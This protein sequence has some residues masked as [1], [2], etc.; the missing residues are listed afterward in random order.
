MFRNERIEFPVKLTNPL[1]AILYISN[2]KTHIDELK[3]ALHVQEI[4]IG[5][6]FENLIFIQIISIFLLPK[7]PQQDA[8][9]IAIHKHG[10]SLGGLAT[11][12]WTLFFIL[13][14]IFHLFLFKL[15]YRELCASTNNDENSYNYKKNDY[16]R[17]RNTRTV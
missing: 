2:D 10:H 11:L 16:R 12:F 7:A 1:T 15:I 5:K 13:I 14:L 9:S 4:E 6:Y 8:H 3:H 17:S